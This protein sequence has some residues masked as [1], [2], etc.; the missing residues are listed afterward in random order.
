MRDVKKELFHE[1]IMIRA[2][3]ERNT[4]SDPDRCRVICLSPGAMP[5][6]VAQGTSG[7]QQSGRSAM[8]LTWALAEGVCRTDYHPE[9]L[10]SYQYQD[11]LKIRRRRRMFQTAASS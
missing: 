5:D 8:Y 1:R 11:I 2:T 3:A 7:G 6:S 10:A 9:R 4:A